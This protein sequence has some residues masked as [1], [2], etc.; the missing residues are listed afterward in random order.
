MVLS[1]VQT[2]L[3]FY[4]EKLPASHVFDFATPFEERFD[5]VEGSRLNSLVF[6]APSPKGLILFF[7]GNA[8]SLAS[9]GLI[10]EDLTRRLGWDVW[11]IDYPGF[12]KSSGS[13][14]SESQLHAM[15]SE[16]FRK[17]RF[18][19]MRPESPKLMIYGRSIGSGLAV[20]LAADE[21][22]DVLVLESPFESLTRLASQYFPWVPNA[23]IRFR[24]PSDE[25]IA[26]VQSPIL[27]LH[28]SDDEIIPV[29]HAE[30]LAARMPRADLVIVDGA[31]HN[32]LGLYP[33]YWSALEA[34]LESE[35]R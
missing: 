1:L 23:L 25:W 3:I 6:R 10:A 11:M 5:D 8:G 13:I 17:A 30:S 19:V 29:G 4:P 34:F 21:N 31:G 9:W 18:E 35:A 12:G 16:L 20:K 27:I 7:H 28:G 14:K 2:N 26:K 32:D 33:E 22:I 15:A 24:F